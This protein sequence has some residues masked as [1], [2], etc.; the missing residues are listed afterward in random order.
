MLD[1]LAGDLTPARGRVRMS[2]RALAGYSRAE[3]AQHRAVL[4]QESAPA[5]AF[6]VREICALG[7]LP[8]RRG[9]AAPSAYIAAF[10]LQH[11][12]DVPFD[13]LSGGER[14]RAQIVRVLTQVD[15]VADALVLL[16]EPT[17]QLDLRHQQTLIAVLRARAAAG[18]VVIAAVHDLNFALAIADRI[19]LL[20]DGRI[21][22]DAAPDTALT[23][24]TIA[25]VFGV[26]VEFV[27]TRAGRLLHVLGASPVA[28]R[29]PWL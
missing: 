8:H 12:L 15:D 3:L 20:R 10:Q 7:H 11:L 2:G 19:V 21:V 24:A 14:Q 4:P 6:T 18:A 1:V 9:S 25:D 28:S 5:F 27:S 13:R 29:P 22:A 23:A 26:D 16:D 17:N